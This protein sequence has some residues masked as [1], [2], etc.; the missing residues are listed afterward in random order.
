MAGA[1]TVVKRPALGPGEKT[2]RAAWSL[3]ACGSSHGRSGK[4][5][6]ESLRGSLPLP[7]L[8]PPAGSSGCSSG[9]RRLPAA[10][11][12][13]LPWWPRAPGAG[14]QQVPPGATVG[15]GP[16]LRQGANPLGLLGTA[17]DGV[18]GGRRKACLGWGWGQVRGKLFGGGSCAP[19]PPR[20]DR[21]A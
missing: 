14:T 21:Q 1:R 2:F 8:V 3:P 20:Q 9:A 15:R 18:G 19:G 6:L 4:L 13:P 5:P 10:G 17:E 7:S 16:E 12:A 11:P